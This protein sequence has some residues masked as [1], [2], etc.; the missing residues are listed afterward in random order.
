MLENYLNSRDKTL[1]I[2]L[3]DDLDGRTTTNEAMLRGL[4]R[5]Y[6]LG[7]VSIFNTL[8]N[9]MGCLTMIDQNLTSVDDGHLT[10]IASRRVFDEIKDLNGDSD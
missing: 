5:K 3:R 8:C 2:R 10:D 9:P 7:Y 6:Q 1:P 4:A